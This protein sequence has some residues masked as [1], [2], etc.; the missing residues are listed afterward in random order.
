MSTKNVQIDFHGYTIS[1]SCGFYGPDDESEGAVI[2]EHDCEDSYLEKHREV[3]ETRIEDSALA[4]I[5][6]NREDKAARTYEVYDD[7]DYFEDDGEEDGDWGT[8]RF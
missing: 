2:T 4:S 6:Q 3:I 7:E 1:G 5:E 8:L